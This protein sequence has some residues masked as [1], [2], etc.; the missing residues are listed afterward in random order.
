MAYLMNKNKEFSI[1]KIEKKLKEISIG[2]NKVIY[3]INKG[4]IKFPAIKNI[5]AENKYPIYNLNL[6]FSER[7][8]QFPMNKRYL[9]INKI[10]SDLLD[11]SNKN[12]IFL[13]NIEILFSKHLRVNFSNLFDICSRNKILLIFWPGEYKDN[14]LIY[15][16]LSHEE[17]IDLR[18][19]NNSILELD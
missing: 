17:Y 14:K 11:Y 7:L 3:I 18:I 4:K 9:E 8:I 6:F 2:Y 5:L 10:F 16:Y 13:Y 15:A 1:K 12:F 19:D